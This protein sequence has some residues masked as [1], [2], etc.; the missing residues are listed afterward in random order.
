MNLWSGSLG[1]FDLKMVK[2]KFPIGMPD[3]GIKVQLE[4]SA[5]M[6]GKSPRGGIL[7]KL[8]S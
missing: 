6:F 3:V 2:L 4:I 7:K 1:G 8:V 5:V